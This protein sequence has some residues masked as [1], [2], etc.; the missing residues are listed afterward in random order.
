MHSNEDF[1]REITNTPSHDYAWIYYGTVMIAREDVYTVILCST[2]DDGSMLIV[3]D[4]KL[5]N[6]DGL[7]GAQQRC[8]AMQLSTGK[9]TVAVKG[10]Q[11]GGGAY[12]TATYAGPDTEG[13]ARRMVSVVTKL[14]EL[15]PPSEWEMRIYKTSVSPFEVG[16]AVESVGSESVE[17]P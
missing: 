16:S 9:H 12:Q 6:N 7:H 17:R 1:M 4:K 14:P 10:F 11:A 13:I 8:A 15:P 2:S 5:V 3:D